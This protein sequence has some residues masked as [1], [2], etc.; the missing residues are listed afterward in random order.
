[1][2]PKDLRPGGLPLGEMP[3]WGWLAAALL[4]LAFFMVMSSSGSLLAPYLGQLAG[5]TDYLHEFAHDGRHILGV[6]CH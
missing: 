1:M 3:A 6:P 5:T 4:L 2:E